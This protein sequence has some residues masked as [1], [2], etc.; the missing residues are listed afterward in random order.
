MIASPLAVPDG[1]VR[2]STFRCPLTLERVSLIGCRFILLAIAL[3]LTPVSLYAQPVNRPT[4]IADGTLRDCQMLSIDRAVAVGDRGL[5]LLTTTGGRTWTIQTPRTSATLLAVDFF[6]EKLGV[7]VGGSVEPTTHRSVGTLL[8][9]EDGG[10]TWKKIDTDL[11]RLTGVRMTGPGR[12]LAWGDWS[13]LYQTAAFES[14]DG[15]RSWL[16]I[17]VPSGHLH[18]IAAH[19]GSSSSTFESVPPQLMAVDRLGR[20]FLSFDRMTFQPSGLNL[21]PYQSIHFCE[22]VDGVWWVG[23]SSGQLYRSADG[24]RWEQVFVPG[25]PRDYELIDF[26]AMAASGDTIWLVGNP[27]SVVWRSTDRG[28][29]WSVLPTGQRSSLRGLS[30]WDS[31]VLLACGDGGSLHL[32]RNGGE[33]WM[34]VHSATTRSSVLN[35]AATADSVAWDLLAH[36]HQESRQTAS[37]V[38]VHDQRI[39]ERSSHLPEPA[40]RVVEAGNH[41]GLRTIDVWRPFPVSSQEAMPRQSDLTYYQSLG[42][43]TTPPE[44]ALMRRLIQTIRCDQPDVVVTECPYTGNSLQSRLSEAVE[45]AIVWSARREWT[46]FSEASSIP[47][48]VWSVDRTIQRGTRSGG[49]QFPRSMFL[50]NSGSVLGEIVTPVQNIVHRNPTR[51]GRAGEERIYYRTL[52]GRKAVPRDPLEGLQRRLGSQLVESPTSISSSSMVRKTAMW[53]E[54][55]DFVPASNPNPLVRDRIWEERLIEAMKG[56]ETINQAPILLEI[57][58]KNRQ[59]GHWN[60]WSSALELLLAVDKR[61]SYA[62]AAMSELMR[63]HGSMEVQQVVLKRIQDMDRREEIDGI[64]TASAST[65][66]SPFARGNDSS[67]VQQAS[68]SHAPRRIPIAVGSGYPEFYRLL[69]DFPSD[70]S[71]LRR[72]P[73]WGWLIASRY[74]ALRERDMITT[75]AKGSTNYDSFWPPPNPMLLGW[76]SVRTQEEALLRALQ[77]QQDVSSPDGLLKMPTTAARPF[78]DGDRGSDN[79]SGAPQVSLRDPW[80]EHGGVTDLYF[81]QDDEFVYVYCNV[82]ASPSAESATP[83]GERRYDSVKEEQEQVRLRFDLDR[84]Y[85]TWFE[86][87]WN[88]KGETSDRCNDLFG[89]NPNWY[90]AVKENGGGWST[91][92]AIPKSELIA[93]SSN[94]NAGVALDSSSRVWA[95]S[96]LHIQPGKSTR[97][98]SPAVSDQFQND[99]WTLIDSNP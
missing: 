11:P 85:A 92:I 36:V 83:S 91:E 42:S 7:A 99:H 87:V 24:Q 96:A 47:N 88:R 44:S 62:E 13:S 60:Y 58:I 23:G 77:T 67:T 90:V 80:G 2:P 17:P 20:C 55:Q 75:P 27:G 3:L 82:S 81:M 52:D 71:L 43:V 22:C 61:S 74:R 49:M 12:I 68:Y 53:F 33:A 59:L 18:S 1:N 28:A 45:L 39:E 89:W 51:L 78:L 38:V 54:Y 31:S 63:F 30:A 35:I 6:N 65:I 37:T 26:Q 34:G 9:T 5:I 29:N 15:G 95:L 72:T 48:E 41:L 8:T 10:R 84:D 57:A 25:N 76:R 21:S 50:K 69:S 40:Q 86:F 70:W 16:S 98:I 32:S 56:I 93:D 46:L 94:P 19:K 4:G 64:S 66:S 73:E 97:T 79:W 14:S